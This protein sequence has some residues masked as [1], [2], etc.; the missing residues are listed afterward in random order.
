MHI[1]LCV[2]RKKVM[3]CGKMLKISERYIGIH[4]I[5]L[6]TFLWVWIFQKKILTEISMHCDLNLSSKLWGIDFLL[7][8]HLAYEETEAQRSL[9][10]CLECDCGGCGP[11]PLTISYSSSTKA[12]RTLLTVPKG[13][14][15]WNFIVGGGY[16]DQLIRYSNL[17]NDVKR[18]QVFGPGSCSV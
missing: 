5:I 15:S 18:G 6:A 10:N 9:V 7:W 8:F 3:K 12:T 17:G 11:G 13:R 16:S 2:C 14:S 1:Y 4:C